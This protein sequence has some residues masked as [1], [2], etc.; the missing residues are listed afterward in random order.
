MDVLAR[1]KPE[2]IAVPISRRG[3]G[4]AAALYPGSRLLGD[5]VEYVRADLHEGAV[6]ESEQLKRTLDTAHRDWRREVE[7]L[8]A[9]IARLTAAGGR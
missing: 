1:W 4:T 8:E 9:Q 2:R 3:L 6:A 7:A 5:E